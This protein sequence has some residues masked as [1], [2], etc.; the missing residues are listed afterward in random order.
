MC[1]VAPPPDRSLTRVPR[2]AVEPAASNEPPTNETRLSAETSARPAPKTTRRAHALWS[3]LVIACA[4]NCCGVRRSRT[5]IHAR[6]RE[7]ERERE[8]DRAMYSHLTTRRIQK[9]ICTDSL[10]LLCHKLSLHR[11]TVKQE[12][13]RKIGLLEIN[14]SR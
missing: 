6:E 14:T 1:A 2:R 9:P 10:S 11:I 7:R 3:L 13:C 4:R 5:R 8:R 12:N